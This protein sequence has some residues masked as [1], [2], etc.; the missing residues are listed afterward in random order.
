M[1]HD[2]R[3]SAPPLRTMVKRHDDGVRGSATC[4]SEAPENVHTNAPRKPPLGGMGGQTCDKSIPSSIPNC[5]TGGFEQEACQL[6]Q[7]ENHAGTHL[8]LC[9]YLRTMRCWT[10]LACDLLVFLTGLQYPMVLRSTPTIQQC[11][12]LSVCLSGC[13]AQRTGFK[14]HQTPHL[15][16]DQQIQLIIWRC[17]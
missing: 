3:T 9:E 1:T 4:Q 15:P 8:S 11:S 12:S 14:I 10:N 5:E 2:C 7:L 6:G 17:P 16:G 13:W